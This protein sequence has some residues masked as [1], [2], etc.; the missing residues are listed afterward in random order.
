MPMVG[1]FYRHFVMKSVPD[2]LPKRPFHCRCII[3]DDNGYII[4]DKKYVEESSDDFT[5]STLNAHLV[6][7]VNDACILKS[8]KSGTLNL[9]DMSMSNCTSSWQLLEVM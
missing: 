1:L 6:Q 4:L 9:V 5:E 2:P 3:I 7:E 8:V